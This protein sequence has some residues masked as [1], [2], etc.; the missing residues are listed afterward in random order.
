M[1]K[2]LKIS[3]VVITTLVGIL[4][5]LNGY[6][7]FTKVTFS[8]RDMGP[9]LLVYDKW[10]GDYK[11]TG[12]IMKNVS[13]DLLE[14]HGIKCAS[15]FGLYLDNPQ[16]VPTEK[17]RSIGGCVVTGRTERQLKA[18]RLKFDVYQFPRTRSVVS[19]FPFKG[20][21]SIVLGVMKV[22]PR[23]SEFLIAG[24]I[25]PGPVME[26]YNASKATIT[27]ISPIQLPLEELENLATGANVNQ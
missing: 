15:R 24:N 2:T 5:I 12:A 4:L 20:T 21:L 23:L 16:K 17:L 6:G 3:F 9:Y 25:R 26:L 19:D 14:Q 13:N 11:V 22:Y 1:K 18:L 27:Y 7:L 10:V 8:K